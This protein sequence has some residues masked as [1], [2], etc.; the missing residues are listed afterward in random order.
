MRLVAVL[1]SLLLL[2]AGGIF[3]IQKSSPILYLK[4]AVTFDVFGMNKEASKEKLRLEGIDLLPISN[5]K[6]AILINR[7]IFLG[8]S[9]T[10]VELALGNPMDKSAAPIE[11]GKPVVERWIYHF[12]EDINPTALEFQDGK[13]TSAFNVTRR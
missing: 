9:P 7:T 13:L 3:M 6:K 12:A 1:A 2:L 5:E 8:A 4:L 11:A 10:M